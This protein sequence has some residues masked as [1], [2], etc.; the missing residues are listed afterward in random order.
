[1]LSRIRPDPLMM[2]FHCFE[3]KLSLFPPYTL[4]FLQQLGLAYELS[5]SNVQPK[6]SDHINLA[7][8]FGKHDQETDY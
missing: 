7:F 3:T 1:M 8:A 5:M 4:F 6:H 2:S